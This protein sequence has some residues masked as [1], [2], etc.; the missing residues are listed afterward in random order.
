MI[1]ATHGKRAVDNLAQFKPHIKAH[2][3]DAEVQAFEESI[4]FFADANSGTVSFL[5]TYRC[6]FL[7]RSLL[8]SPLTSRYS[9][10]LGSSMRSLLERKH[11]RSNSLSQQ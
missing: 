4:L 8:Y 11:D 7:A 10:T 6:P 1:A 2:E 3:M 5:P 9:Q